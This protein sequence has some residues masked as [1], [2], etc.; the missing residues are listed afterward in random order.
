MPKSK[1]DKKVSLTKTTKKGLQAKHSLVEQIRKSVEQYK[2][3]FVFSVENMRNGKLKNL[4]GDWN[5]SRFF[6]GKNKVMTLGLGRKKEDEVEDNLHKL[7]AKLKGQ[8]GL[9]FTN[10]SNDDVT[11]FFDTYLE[12]DYARSGFVATETVVV[13]EGPLPEFPHS[14]EP[15]LR[16]LGLPTSLKK[17]VVTLLT[18]H[19]VCNEGDVLTPEQARILKLLDNRM[20]Q[21]KISLICMWSKGGMFKTKN[22]SKN[23]KL[24]ENMETETEET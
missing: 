18:D 8:C 11:K 19:K 10:R 13:P 2:N 15:Q 21:F 5:D 23:K 24:E 16:Q 17:G 1:R 4:R 7:S 20:A 9:L 6:F 12:K 14:M 22:G 3:I